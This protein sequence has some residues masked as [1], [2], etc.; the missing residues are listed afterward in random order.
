MDVK[1]LLESIDAV[2][3]IS[4][5]V[6]LEQVGA[7]FWGLS[8]FQ[9]ENTPSFSVRR[10]SG[11]W[12]D[13]SAGCGGDLISFVRR[14]HK[15]GFN[16]SLEILSEYAGEDITLPSHEKMEA[17]KVSRRFE[18][19]RSE[20]KQSSAKV[21]PD[22][23]MERFEENEEK[24]KPWADEGIS[25][26]SMRKF[27][28][29]FDAVA[30]RIVYPIRN[31]DGK[32]ISVHGRTMDADFKA[33]KIRKYTYYTPI[34]ILDTLYGLSEHRD[35]IKTSREIILFEGAKSVML[36]DTWGIYNTAA[37]MTSHLNGYQLRIL[38]GLGV[39]V[40]FALDQ[41]VNIYLDDNIRRL[42]RYV[43]VEVVNDN[44]HLLQPKMSPVDAGLETWEQLYQERSV[45]K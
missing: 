27:Q 8:P 26:E 13:F 11:Q 18:T 2:E 32:I 36:A 1:E 16:Q 42:K 15:C 10:E 19:K 7:E 34:G 38:A 33:K 4:Q 23:Y 20:K 31:V 37:I 9:D 29:R 45:W 12:Y 6:E 30:N 24:L 14:Y 21:L 43:A 40:V 25:Y 28:V 35:A 5:Y 44:K 39:R 3:Y 41:D 22:N 17:V